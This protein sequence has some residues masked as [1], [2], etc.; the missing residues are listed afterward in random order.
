M[1]PLYHRS[2]R[3]KTVWGAKQQSQVRQ[4]ATWGFKRLLVGA[5]SLAGILALATSA[6]AGGRR[7]PKMDGRLEQRAL[8]GS[9]LNRSTVIVTLTHGD[10]L[11]GR[12]RNYRTFDR[13]NGINGYV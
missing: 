13:F 6:S 2:A 8:R 9:S 7:Y 4:K 12:L 11:P 3:R 1:T 10:D 5:V